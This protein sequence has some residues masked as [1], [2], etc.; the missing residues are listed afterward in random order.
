M[1]SSDLSLR[2]VYDD[3]HPTYSVT[4]R[5]G[6]PGHKE[7]PEKIAS[8]CCWGKKDTD[9]K[10]VNV[11]V[12]PVSTQWSDSVVGATRL[13]FTQA[14][15]NLSIATDHGHPRDGSPQISLCFVRSR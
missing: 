3:P 11:P 6:V 5:V 8:E 13:V 12:I 2:C 9:K 7:D 14:G 15:S 4:Q 1:C 10:S